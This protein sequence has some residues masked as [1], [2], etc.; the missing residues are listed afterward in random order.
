MSRLRFALAA[1]PLPRVADGRIVLAADV[2]PWLRPDAATC[3]D[4][5]FCHT[6]GRGDTKHLMIP[7]W[8]YSIVAALEVG[9]TSWTALLDAMRLEPGADVA[10]LTAVQV[11][12][13]VERLIEAGQWTASDPDIL[14][15][16]DAGYDVPRLAFLLQDLPVEVLGR[17][18]SDRVMRRATPPRVYNPEGG[19]PPKH[20]GEFV[21]GDPTTGARRRPPQSPL[22]R[23]TAPRRPPRGTGCIPG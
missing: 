13:V 1:L 18:R 4:R 7:G 22:P 6:Y 11:R 10:S 17:M 12:Q 14:I 15:V 21:F 9:R 8:P 2:S 5:S 20:G 16:V 23:D 19:R 3:P